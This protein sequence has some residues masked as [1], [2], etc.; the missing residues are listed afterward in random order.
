MIFDMY[1]TLEDFI[2]KQND[3]IYIF[4]TE[5][6]KYDYIFDINGKYRC[7]MTVI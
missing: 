4:S 7:N 5:I 1:N 6:N 2:L 3:Y